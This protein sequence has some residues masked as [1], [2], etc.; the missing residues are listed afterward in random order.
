[1]L[2]AACKLAEYQ[3]LEEKLITFLRSR[4]LAGIR[5][6]I[7]LLRPDKD[8]AQRHIQ[9]YTVHS[10][11]HGLDRNSHPSFYWTYKVIRIILHATTTLNN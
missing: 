7:S 9:S 10:C 3:I 5:Q 4:S 8:T 1:M 6:L 11:S 2:C